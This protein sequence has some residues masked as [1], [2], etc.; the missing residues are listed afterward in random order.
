MLQIL[1]ADGYPLF[2]DLLKQQVERLG[3]FE[4]LVANTLGDAEAKLRNKEYKPRAVFWGNKFPDGELI[5]DGVVE[6]TLPFFNPNTLHILMSGTH[7]E[8][9]L[10]RF[11]ALNINCHAH[12]KVESLESLKILL[13]MLK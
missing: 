9:Q 4:V 11:Q 12:S 3:G 6:R 8:Q 1:I 7:W 10:E 5:G 13:A 2:T